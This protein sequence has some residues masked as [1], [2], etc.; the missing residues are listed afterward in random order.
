MSGVAT[1]FI[2]LAFIALAAFFAERAARSASRARAR[3][4]VVPHTR[5]SD[6]ASAFDAD[7]VRRV[8]W[9]LLGAALALWWGGVMW[10]VAV[11]AVALSIRFARERRARAV[12][13][14][15][16]EEQLADAVGALVSAIRAGMSIPQAFAYAAAEA[17]PPL[18]DDLGSLVA[19]LDVGV[20]LH[21]AL[22]LWADRMDSDDARL[23]AAAMELHRRAGGDLPTV[24]A[25]VTATVRE[26]V[27]A[28]RDVRAMTAQARLSGAI[29][30][31]LP[32]GF[33]VFLWLTSRSEIEGALRTPLGVA[34]VVLGLTLDGVAFLWIRRLLEIE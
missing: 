18:A 13:R 10:A 15:R 22:T 16:R 4:S 7:R 6:A 33:F 21:D 1:A 9:P 8:G 5:D 32:V 23:I 24:L 34:C 27:A 19:A 28:S 2:A 31:M 11:G 12:V 17:E 20:P 29:L 30:G 14:A 3:S 25:Q 26:R